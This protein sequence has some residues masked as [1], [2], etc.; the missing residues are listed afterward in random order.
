MSWQKNYNQN[1]QKF[2]MFGNWFKKTVTPLAEQVIHI[3]MHSHLLPGIDDGSPDFKSSLQLIK[4]LSARGYTKLI[5]TPHIMGDYYRNTPE[6]ILPLLDELKALLLKENIPVA[7]EAAAE[8]FLDEQSMELLEQDK[9]LLSFG[10]KYVLFETNFISEPM[11]LKEFIFMLTTKGYKPVLAHPERYLYLFKNFDTIKDLMNRG[12]YMQVNLSSITGYYSKQAQ[13]M[14][15]ELIDRQWVHF[16][17]SDCHHAQHIEVM[18]KAMQHKYYL[19]ALNLNL[20]NNA[21]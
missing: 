5:T 10:D 21:L 19:K 2:R 20:L 1:Y 4:A 18:D 15:F 6:N 3:D 12:V 13:Q 11:F 17:G 14:A 7:I 8:Y 16:L 9:E